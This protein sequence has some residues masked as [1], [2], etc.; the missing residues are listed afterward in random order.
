MKNVF[1]CLTFILVSF[2]SFAKSDKPSVIVPNSIEATLFSGNTTEN[3]DNVDVR[4]V[5]EA[6]SCYAN[7]YYNGVLQHTVQS[8][9]Y[10]ET[11]SEAEAN[12]YKNAKV[13]ALAW[14]TMQEAG[15]QE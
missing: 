6:F 5:F 4:Y 15:L 11:S 3:V 12:C 9:G 2:C 7:I 8:F 10:A 13:V 14:I 1:F